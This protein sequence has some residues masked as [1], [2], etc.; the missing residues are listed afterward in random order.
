VRGDV[1][2]DRRSDDAIGRKIAPDS[3]EEENRATLLDDKETQLES[4]Q[5]VRADEIAA[6][7]TAMQ[8]NIGK[9]VSSQQLGI[10]PLL[11]FQRVCEVPC[12]FQYLQRARWHS[13][14]AMGRDP[15][16]TTLQLIN[17]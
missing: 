13:P 17:L 1:H 15:T 10:S 14:I 9:D 5:A 11:L 7:H 6:A 2:G 8:R 3:I 16:W 12:R 4:R